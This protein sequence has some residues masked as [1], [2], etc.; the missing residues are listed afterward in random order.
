MR[1]DTIENA[2][3]GRS[4]GDDGTRSGIARAVASRQ[5]RHPGSIVLVQH[6]TLWVAMLG[7]ALA[8]RSD[9][10]LALSTAQLLPARVRAPIRVFTSIVAVGIS[11]SLCVAS[12][13]LIRIE[14]AAGDVVAWGIPSWVVLAVL[15]LGFAAISVRL[16]WHA[17]DG[18]AGRRRGMGATRR[19]YP[20][21]ASHLPGAHHRLIAPPRLDAD[22]PRWRRSAP[23]VLGRRTPV[24]AVPGEAYG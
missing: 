16:V 11:A 23:A 10:L 17:A 6:L 3:R 18:H 2:L 13:D 19:P 9:R 14:R 12:A 4:R 7:A 5:A 8:A 20:R 21:S 15:P 1:A 24:N 22:S